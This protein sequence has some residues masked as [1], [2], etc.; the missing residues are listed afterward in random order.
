MTHLPLFYALYELSY[1]SP[2]VI[3]FIHPFMPVIKYI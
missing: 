1:K 3:T 2:Q